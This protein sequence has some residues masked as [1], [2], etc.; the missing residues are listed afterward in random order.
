MLGDLLGQSQS[1]HVCF[2]VWPASPSNT[3]YRLLT[4]PSPPTRVSALGVRLL[5]LLDHSWLHHSIQSITTHPQG[6]VQWDKEMCMY[7]NDAK[8]LLKFWRGFAGNAIIILHRLLCSYSF[9]L[10]FAWEATLRPSE[11]Q[12]DHI[13]SLAATLHSTQS[14]EN[15]GT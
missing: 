6:S 9:L 15:G 13:H 5:N 7:T 10:Y 11:I 1:F 12:K 2:S 8:V 14:E 4:Q 3:E